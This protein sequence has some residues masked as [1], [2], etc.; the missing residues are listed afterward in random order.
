MNTVAGAMKSF[1]S[2]LP[3]PLVPYNMQM[4]LVEA[5]SEYPQ[6]AWIVGPWWHPSLTLLGCGG[7]R[8][9][10]QQ[11][12]NRSRP[13]RAGALT[14]GTEPEGHRKENQQGGARGAHIRPQPCRPEGLRSV[15][16]KKAASCPE[17]PWLRAWF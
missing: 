7:G 16:V 11:H 10:V 4:D 17:A 13:Q 5:H 12:K 2:E 8:G 9:A 15:T 14:P 3:D 6:P 1:F